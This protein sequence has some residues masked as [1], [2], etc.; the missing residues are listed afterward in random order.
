MLVE[1]DLADL[2]AFSARRCDEA[3]GDKCMEA[4]YAAPPGGISC[5]RCPICIACA[6]PWSPNGDSWEEAMDGV[7]HDVV[8]QI[9]SRTV[10]IVGE[11][12]LV[13]PECSIGS[14][15]HRY[16]DCNHNHHNQGP[17]RGK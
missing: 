7:Y 14:C 10:L 3:G 11:S 8:A 15:T 16:R 4:F 12:M 13:P 2:C 5:P 17:G 1:V 6:G 9:R